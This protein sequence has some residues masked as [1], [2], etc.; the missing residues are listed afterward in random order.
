MAMPCFLKRGLEGAGSKDD[1]RPDAQ[2]GF[3]LLEGKGYHSNLYVTHEHID[4]YLPW[5]RGRF[6]FSFWN[7]QKATSS[8][9]KL[10]FR[11]KL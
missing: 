10:A 9:S 3:T 1:G 11:D 6:F 7:Q 5:K 2:R 8:V 4:F